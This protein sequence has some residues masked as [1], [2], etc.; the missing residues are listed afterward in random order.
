MKKA[1]CV[2]INNY[3]GTAND[4]NGCVNDANDWSSLLNT[5]GFETNIILNEQATQNNILEAFENLITEAKNGDVVVF[6]YSGHGTS[7]MD[8]SGDENDSYD[9]ALYVYDGPIIDDKFRAILT[10]S[11]KDV[12]IIVI[13]DSCFSGT[14]TRIV[15]LDPAKPRYFKTDTIPPT[16]VLKKRFLSK[17][18]EESMIELLLSG[19]SDSEYSYDAYINGRWN[20]A[21]TANA[22]SIIDPEQT[23]NEFYTKLR[24]ILPS[25]E[26]PQTPQL[27]GSEVNKNKIIFSSDADTGDDNTDNESD[28]NNGSGSGCF[29]T[30]L[31]I[32]AIASLSIILLS[33]TL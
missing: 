24:T 31:S 32:I 26:Y 5:Y 29:S 14:V 23:Y 2:G 10:N 22:I 18:S 3:P 19:C 16:A 1:I 9:E 27:E 11:N 21:M 20:G 13:T 8:T 15:A 17:S 30:L 4:L 6:T 33:I 25:A 7:V 12:Q 28:N